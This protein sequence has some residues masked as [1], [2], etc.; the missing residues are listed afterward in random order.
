V[1]AVVE[2]E[3]MVLGV[4]VEVEAVPELVVLAAVVAV[5]AQELSY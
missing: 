1:V 2:A 3:V 4:E 5:V